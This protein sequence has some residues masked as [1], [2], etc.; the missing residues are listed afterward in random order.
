MFREPIDPATARR[1][2]IDGNIYLARLEE[3]I[4]T[5]IAVSRIPRGR[6]PQEDLEMTLIFFDERGNPLKEM[7]AGCAN[8]TIDDLSDYVLAA[9]FRSA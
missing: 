6:P 4:V 5:A 1:I 2:E 7:G 9:R 3:P 8:C